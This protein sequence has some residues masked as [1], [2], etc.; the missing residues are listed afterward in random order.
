[1]RDEIEFALEVNEPHIVTAVDDDVAL[2]VLQRRARD[3]AVPAG[4]TLCIDPGSDRAKPRPTIFV[5]E[6]N[7]A[8]HLRHVGS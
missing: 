1:M 6:R 5:G 3:D 8:A 7:A 4:C 2:T